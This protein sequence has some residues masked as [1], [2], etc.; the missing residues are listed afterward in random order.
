M[1][2]Y[3]E[4]RF[5]SRIA[6]YLMVVLL[7]L[8]IFPIS[9]DV[10]EEYHLDYGDVA[11][12]VVICIVFWFWAYMNRLNIVGLVYT[13]AAKA[14]SVEIVLDVIMVNYTN[15]LFHYIMFG[16][17][18][19]HALLFISVILLLFGSGGG[20]GRRKK[21]KKWKMPKLPRLRPMPLP[22]PTTPP[23]H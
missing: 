3:M 18:V 5:L 10:G 15:V 12:T 21:R 13:R 16:Q 17:T 9:A 23:T 6:F 2:R 11:W 4:P 22:K 1:S 14:Y 19:A 7:P 20:G 8:S